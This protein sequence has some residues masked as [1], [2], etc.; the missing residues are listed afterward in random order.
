MNTCFYDLTNLIQ[1]SV[2]CIN[3]Q[4]Q[5]KQPWT[6]SNKQIQTALYESDFEFFNTNHINTY[7]DKRDSN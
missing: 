3:K 6:Q 7:F 2:T 5:P 1:P 4:Q